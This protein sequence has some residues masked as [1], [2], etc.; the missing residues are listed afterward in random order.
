M[1]RNDVDM[2]KIRAGARM[3]MVQDKYKTHE[4][5]GTQ[6][7]NDAAGKRPGLY[8]IKKSHRPGI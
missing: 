3:K 2:Y 5:A 8:R 1:G 6:E 4:R 7:Q